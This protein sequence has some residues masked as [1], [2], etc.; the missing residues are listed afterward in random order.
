MMTPATAATGNEVEWRALATMVG[1]ASG[2][3]L[4]F[5]VA[6]VPALLD[7]TVARLIEA[8]GADAVGT[9]ALEASDDDDL[10]D[11]LAAAAAPSSVRVVVV[12]G[13]ADLVDPHGERPNRALGRL[14]FNRTT[15]ANVCRKPLLLLLPTWAL[16][17]L[18][19]GAPDLWSWRSGMYRL[20]G[21]CEELAELVASLPIDGA[22]DR[23]A[24]GATRRVLRQL[25]AELVN[26]DERLALAALLRLGRVETLLGEYDA[27]RKHYARSLTIATTLNDP[28]SEVRSVLGIAE[29]ARIQG[30]YDDARER[31]DHAFTLAT[32]LDDGASETTSLLG[33]AE[34][35]RAGRL[36]KRAR[37]LRRGADPCHHPRPPVQPG[38][39]SARAREDRTDPGLL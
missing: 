6:D 10:L 19:R 22:A 5:V 27:A 13:A 21:G 1:I 14:N 9:V 35:A 37:A 36:R 12:R 32:S 31:Y 26:G 4:G 3:S 33:L 30:D 11:R 8:L 2:F 17:E 39:R 24:R 38:Q 18:A 15:L 7:A 28:T 25:L 23:R 34:I 20:G 16:R 29:I